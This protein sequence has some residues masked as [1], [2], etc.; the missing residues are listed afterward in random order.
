MKRMFLQGTVWTGI[1]KQ[2]TAWFKGIAILLIA[3][4][5]F[6]HLIK[7]GMPGENEFSFNPE[8]FQNFLML[9]VQDYPDAVRIVLHYLGHY[10]VQVFIFLSAYGL[11][12]K[13]LATR[14]VYG[15]YL[16]DR[17]GKIYP[18]FLLSV[19]LFLLYGLVTDGLQGPWKLVQLHWYAIL[20]KLTLLSNFIPG[21]ALKPVGPWWFLPFIFQFYLVFPFILG[22]SKK[23]GGRVLLV[24]ACAGIL[25]SY[26]F[27][28]AEV[29]VYFTVLGHLPELC[30]GIYLAGRERLRVPYLAAFAVL[31]LFILGN[32]Y[33]PFWYLSHLCALILLL[34]AFNGLKRAIGAHARV[35]RLLVFYGSLSMYLFFVNG[36]LRW[37]LFI[38]ARELDHWAAS[39]LLCAAFLAIATVA[40]YALSIAEQQIR[41][42]CAQRFR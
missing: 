1:S 41:R 13:Y 4:H 30:L 25:G 23:Y 35:N 22:L 5:N 16:L 42:R 6:L 29:N 15:G 36:F 31:I 19:L 18:A 7:D 39:L 9:L 26:V 20:L 40:S 28:N 10:G 11:T 2:E 34:L 37:P 21:M 12:K 24:I 17:F 8:R 38:W 32:M 33:F 27:R 3:A 14:L